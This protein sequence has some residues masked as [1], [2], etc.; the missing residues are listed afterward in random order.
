M[1]VLRM[2]YWLALSIVLSTALSLSA[3][4]KAK[5]RNLGQVLYETCKNCHGPNGEGNMNIEAPGINAMPAW[6]I[7]SSLKK[8]QKGIRG[9]HHADAAG[10]RMRPLSRH[11]KTDAEIKAVAEYIESLT[12]VKNPIT[13][14]GDAEK[15]KMNYMTCLAC[16]GPE[17]QGN[18]ALKAPPIKLL[19]DWYIVAQ[20]KKYRNGQR[21]YSAKD[22]EG[23]QMKGMAMA[24]PN[25]QALADVAAYIATFNKGSS[26]TAAVA[27]PKKEEAH[28]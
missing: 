17:G 10:L 15:G 1:S 3:A 14:H 9:A 20:L 19:P 7:I 5:E 12:P 4:P 8:Y 27:K 18:P 11:L 28:H 13:V 23:Q 2:K 26:K 21:A 6:Y 16:H 25:E 22:I 24:L